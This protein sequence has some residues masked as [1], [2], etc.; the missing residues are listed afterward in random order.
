MLK[1]LT[2]TGTAIMKNIQVVGGAINC[3]YDLYAATEEDF[4]LIFPASN[5]DIQGIHGTLFYEL[6][7]KRQFH[8]NKQDDNITLE[9]GHTQA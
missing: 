6:P 8:S 2:K 3:A 4:L 7:A 1:S 5:Q 9:L